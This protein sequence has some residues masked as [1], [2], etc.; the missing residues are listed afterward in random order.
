MRKKKYIHLEPSEVI[1]LEEG[2]KNVHHSQFQNRCHALLLS[3]NG[4]DMVSISKIFDVTHGTISN[5]LNYWETGGI[6]GLKNNS[7]QGR[8][9]I[10]TQA[11]LPLI[12]AKVAE[13]PQQLKIV[14]EE[15]KQELAKEFSEK[16]LQR[17]LKTLVK[18][19]GSVAVNA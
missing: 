10:L 5:W 2:R 6:V 11:D 9:P 12:K 1:T 13:N 16:T 15:L 19:L 18:P 4:Y 17:F 8:K 3:H 7:G 14:R